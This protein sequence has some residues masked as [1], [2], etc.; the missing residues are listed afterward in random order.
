[1][2]LHLLTFGRV[3]PTTVGL[4]GI[5]HACLTIS[6]TA[7]ASPSRRLTTRKRDVLTLT[8]VRTQ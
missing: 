5:R 1:M 6:N 4:A 3:L 8:D 7:L 2:L